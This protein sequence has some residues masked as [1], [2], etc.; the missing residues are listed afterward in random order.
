MEAAENNPVP[1]DTPESDEPPAKRSKPDGIPTKA[2]HGRPGI[3]NAP[4]VL[5]VNPQG[6]V[7]VA[8]PAQPPTTQ[9]PSST[10]SRPQPTTRTPTTDMP[11]TNPAPPL[12]R[13]RNEKRGGD[14]LEGALA[15][16]QRGEAKAL[17]K[18]LKHVGV[19]VTEIC[20]LP[21]ATEHCPEEGLLP[22]SSLDLI[23]CDEYGR[24][25]DFNKAEM[26]QHAEAIIRKEQTAL[27]RWTPTCTHW[28]SL[29]AV[30]VE[31]MG[32]AEWARRM[33]ESRV[34]L[35]FVCRMYKLQADAG[36]YY[37][38]EHP[39]TARRWKEQCVIRTMQATNGIQV[40]GDMCR[41]GMTTRRPGPYPGLAFKTTTS[42]TNL[43][44]IAHQLER[45]CLNKVFST[46][47]HKHLRLEQGLC[48]QAQV[49]PPELC[50]AICR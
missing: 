29:Q 49:W 50:R 5:R 38:H 25:Y 16:A 30:N 6:Q 21:R 23:A 37:L 31:R 39:A 3:I 24:P 14:R 41:F 32:R 17:H 36:R 7:E 1:D 44:C 40:S 48:T 42:M 13:T 11:P 19:D 33:H 43:L 27:L 22:G 26:R 34:H 12:T 47:D 20:L 8:E 46:T 18:L 4:Q 35:E 28:C 15:K 10:D 9:A 2:D 45:P